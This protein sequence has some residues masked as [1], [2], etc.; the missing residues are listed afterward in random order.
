M[1]IKL[2]KDKTRHDSHVKEV[3]EEKDKKPVSGETAESILEAGLEAIKPDFEKELAEQKDK[4]FRLYAEFENYK[5]R[6]IKDKEEIAN[7]GNES[8]IYDLLPVV[9]NLEMALK[10]SADNAE[11]GEGFVQGVEITLKEFMKVLGRFGVVPIEAQGKHFDPSVHHAMSI[12]E[13][14]DVE[15]NT[16]IE[17]LRKGYML[18]D[19]VLRPSLVT[20]SKKKNEGGNVNEESSKTEKSENENKINLNNEEEIQNG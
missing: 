4:Y 7:Y 6:I 9:D 3:A 11:A 2:K 14:D 8:L 19:K 12:A 13:K 1:K 18:K 5:K 16:I 10:H 15:A 20:V 17:E